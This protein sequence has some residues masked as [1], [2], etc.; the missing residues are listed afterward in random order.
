M[1]SSHGFLTV[2]RRLIIGPVVL[3]IACS[4]LFAQQ[5][6]GPAPTTAGL[7]KEPGAV[8]PASEVAAKPVVAAP[9]APARGEEEVVVLSPFEVRA[10]NK[11]YLAANSMSGTRFNSRIGIWRCRSRW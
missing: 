3:T 7:P 4:S 11:G 9:A 10:D 8:P 1:N 2:F 5:A 6:P